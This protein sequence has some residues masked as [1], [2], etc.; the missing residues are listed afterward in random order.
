VA[1]SSVH[2]RSVPRRPL[3]FLPVARAY[4]GGEF[5]ACRP[6]FDY[7][8]IGTAMSASVVSAATRVAHLQQ[9]YTFRLERLRESADCK[10]PVVT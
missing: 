8:P 7:I 5:V 3:T 9:W 4:P 10:G 2:F 1:R 6:T